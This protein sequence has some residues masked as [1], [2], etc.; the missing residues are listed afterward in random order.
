MRGRAEGLTKQ[1]R[2]RVTRQNHWNLVRQST[3]PPGIPHQFPGVSEMT[4]TLIDVALFV[5]LKH[6]LVIIDILE[7]ARNTEVVSKVYKTMGPQL[8][9]HHGGFAS[10]S[11]R[12]TSLV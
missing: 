9:V 3:V 5:I 6:D 4:T 2:E 12:H 7:S 11:V 1:L 8:V 10:A